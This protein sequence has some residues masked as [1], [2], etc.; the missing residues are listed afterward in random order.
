MRTASN[1]DQSIFYSLHTECASLILIGFS[2]IVLLRGTFEL[3]QELFG[4]QRCHILF[5]SCGKRSENG[6]IPEVYSILQRPR[7]LPPGNGRFPF[8]TA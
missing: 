5:D 7:L 6:K 2:L 4:S 1:P 8:S 3:V